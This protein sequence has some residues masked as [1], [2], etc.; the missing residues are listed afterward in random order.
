MTKKKPFSNKLSPAETERL[1]LLAEE[2]GEVVHIIGKILRHGYE[3]YHPSGYDTNRQLLTGETGDLYAALQMMADVGDLKMIEVL[4][5]AQDKRE[6]V[7]E[8]LHHQS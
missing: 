6:R 3:S 2:C 7:K 4:D 8:Y 5:A 1:A